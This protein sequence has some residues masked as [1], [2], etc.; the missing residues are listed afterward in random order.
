MLKRHSHT[1]EHSHSD[2]C[3]PVATIINRQTEIPLNCDQC[4]CDNYYTIGHLRQLPQLTCD[5]CE[6]SRRFSEL[7]LAVLEKALKEMGFYLAG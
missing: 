2:Q 4:D 6:D 7:E 1:D 5:F 3:S